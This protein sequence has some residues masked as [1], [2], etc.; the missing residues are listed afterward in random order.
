MKAWIL[1]VVGVLFALLGAVWTLQGLGVL[2]GSVMSGVTAWALIGP[3]VVIVA[4][5]VAV[6][7]VRGVAKRKPRD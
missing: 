2:G 5:V 4:M 7:G 3:V 6:I 1:V